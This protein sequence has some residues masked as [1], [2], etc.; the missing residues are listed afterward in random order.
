[1]EVK[2]ILDELEVRFPNN[3]AIPLRR[4]RWL[5][6]V[7]RTDEAGL[8]LQTCSTS[9]RIGLAYTMLMAA[10]SR[11]AEMGEARKEFQAVLRLNIKHQ[12]HTKATPWRFEDSPHKSRKLDVQDCW[13]V[14]SDAENHFRSAILWQKAI[15]S[16]ARFY[17]SVGWFYWIRPL[18]RGAFF[19]R[20]GNPRSARAF[21]NYWGKGSTFNGS[22]DQLRRLCS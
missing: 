9:F 18:C 1:M 2:K 17:T 8:F 12:W 13:K 10:F 20:R 22:E 14:S 5:A 3:N 16:S 7:G 19:L 4:A 15:G 6:E 21:S 11:L